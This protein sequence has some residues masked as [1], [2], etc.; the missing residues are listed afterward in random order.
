MT[1]LFGD[2]AMFHAPGDHDQ[3]AFTQDNGPVTKFH[4]EFSVNHQEEFVFV[5]V[6]VPIKSAMEFG[7]LDFL[8]IQGSN[9]SG[10]PMVRQLVKTGA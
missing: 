3:L 2:G 1:L 10:R 5:V 4:R 9:N 6:G 7:Q 8:P